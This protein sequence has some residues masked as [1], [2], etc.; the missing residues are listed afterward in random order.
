MFPGRPLR[1]QSKDAGG[2]SGSESDDSSSV[3]SSEEEEEEE[4]APKPK[5]SKA[6][7]AAKSSDAGAAPTSLSAEWRG[8]FTTTIESY[9]VGKEMKDLK[10]SDVRAALNAEHGELAVESLFPAVKTLLTEIIN[11]PKTA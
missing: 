7:P 9:L 6:E 5:K 2:D 8:K 4:S 3:A 1:F 11:K 10:I